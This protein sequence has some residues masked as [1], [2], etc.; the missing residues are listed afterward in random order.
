MY[1]YWLKTG[2]SEKIFTTDGTDI[3]DIKTRKQDSPFV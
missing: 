1:Y 3:A 2:I